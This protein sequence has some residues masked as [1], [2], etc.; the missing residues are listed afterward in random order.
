MPVIAM[1][2]IRYSSPRGIPAGYNPANVSTK[3]RNIAQAVV[4]QHKE[5]INRNYYPKRI[6]SSSERD[7]NGVPKEFPKRR[8]GNLRKSVGYAPAAINIST[9]RKAKSL[10]ISLGYDDSICDP[11]KF[12]SLRYG[13]YGPGRRYLAPRRMM[14]NTAQ[15]VI[16]IELA[17]S[18]P[19]PWTPTAEWRPLTWEVVPS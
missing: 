1:V 5:D 8:T 2:E 18:N 15:S 9:V 11:A 10:T 19:E 6:A 3:L 17:K 16:P 13:A 12:N 14:P 4:R 7:R